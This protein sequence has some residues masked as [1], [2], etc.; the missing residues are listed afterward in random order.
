[1]WSAADC[2]EE[3]FSDAEAAFAAAIEWVEEGRKERPER[4]H[5]TR[6]LPD[7]W[8]IML[9]GKLSLFDTE[10]QALAAL[11]AEQGAK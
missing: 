7:A 1:M 6:N 5:R 10:A 4:L 8:A 3:T 2:P 9:N 11:Q